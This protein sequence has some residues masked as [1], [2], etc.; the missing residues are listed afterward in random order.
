M[1]TCAVKTCPEKAS[2][3][4]CAHGLCVPHALTWLLGLNHERRDRAAWV[5]EQEARARETA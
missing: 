1:T 4:Q 2:A 3:I 5:A